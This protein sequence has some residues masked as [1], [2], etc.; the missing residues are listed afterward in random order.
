MTRPGNNRRT[1]WWVGRGLLVMWFMLMP[2]VIAWL[3]GQD[4]P[5]VFIYGI[6]MVFGSVALVS[7]LLDKAPNNPYL[8]DTYDD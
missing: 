6:A 2:G 8:K 5:Y 1:W 3:F 7:L 4:N